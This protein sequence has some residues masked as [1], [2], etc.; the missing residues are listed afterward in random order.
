MN[1]E[2]YPALS[3]ISALFKIFGWLTLLMGFGCIVWAILGS[4]AY[5]LIFALSSLF[6][7]L[8]SL[9]FAEAII[10]LVDI[11]S[12]TRNGNKVE[13]QAHHGNKVE[14]NFLEIPKSER[15]K[16]LPNCPRCGN[17]LKEGAT[18]C[19]SCGFLFSEWH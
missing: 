7:A 1:N 19:A 8:L 10:V 6:S 9:A 3:I 14:Q 13:Q 15:P 16:W 2:K 11:E 18:G 5:P 4:T 12:N 17:N